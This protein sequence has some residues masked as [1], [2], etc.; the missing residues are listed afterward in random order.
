MIQKLTEKILLHIS[1]VLEVYIKD[2]KI[3]TLCENS[4]ITMWDLNY[5]KKFDDTGQ[6]LSKNS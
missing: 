5:K 1:K 4:T 2:D 6:I 3:F